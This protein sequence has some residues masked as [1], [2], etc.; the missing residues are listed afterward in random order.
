MG[1][2]Q[3]CMELVEQAKASGA[4]RQ[5]SCEVLEVSLRTLERW[6]K[7]PDQGDQRKGP[8]TACGHGLSEEE[9]QAMIEVWQ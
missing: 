6:E 5:A 2:R 7:E 8:K 4:R 9:K 3:N 1:D